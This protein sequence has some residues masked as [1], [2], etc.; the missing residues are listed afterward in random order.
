MS[1]PSDA[2][3]RLGQLY[4]DSGSCSGKQLIPAAWVAEA[5]TA[6]IEQHAKVPIT[7]NGVQYSDPDLASAAL[8][9]SS[10]SY[11]GYGYQI[12]RGRH[13]TYRADG[14]WGQ[15]VL[16]MPEQQAVIV[17]TASTESSRI[18]DAIWEHLLPAMQEAP[19]AS[20]RSAQRRLRERLA[21]LTLACPVGQAI[22]PAAAS[23]AGRTFQLTDNPLGARA[24]SFAWRQ[25]ICTLSLERA[26]GRV[27]IP[28][29]FGR[30]ITS[31]VSASGLVPWMSTFGIRVIE[32]PGSETAISG[33]FAWQDDRTLTLRLQYIE[34]PHYQLVTVRLTDDGLAF[35]VSEGLRP[36]SYFS[37]K[38]RV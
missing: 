24:L 16:V 29:G 34:T 12:W 20:S 37:G 18:L 10:D 11:Q 30:W 28:L 8:R 1:L 13:G 33:A 32:R 5:S 21:G 17:T 14:A 35:E 19:L 22:N 27:T 23:L 3:A 25:D 7:V 36:I 9:A 26:A 38:A 4:L 6:H 31:R 15:L 2:L